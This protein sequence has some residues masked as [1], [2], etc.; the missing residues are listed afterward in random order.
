MSAVGE[1][2]TNM[3]NSEVQQIGED[4][5]KRNAPGPN[6]TADSHNHGEHHGPPLSTYFKVFAAL[7]IL[8]FITVGA[9]LL[10]FGHYGPQFAWMNIVVA[11]IIAVIK[12]M[13]IFVFFMHLKWSTKL[14]WLFAGSGFLWLIVLFTLGLADYFTRGMV[15]LP[16][17]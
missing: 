5:L 15:K 14:V 6:V 11:M 12:A 17:P 8:L 10:D 2:V 3:A 16:N 13:L 9:A 4:L 7:M 1:A